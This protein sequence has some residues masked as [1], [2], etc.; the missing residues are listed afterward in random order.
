M[1]ALDHAIIL[2]RDLALAARAYQRLGFTLT[3][4]GGHPTLGTANHTIVFEHDY[5][6]LLTVLSRAPSNERWAA[7]IDRGD[8]PGAMV[9]NTPDA[10]RTHRGLESRGV[11]AERPIHFERPV[12]TDAGIEAARFSAV[13]LPDEATPAIPA[14]FCQHHTPT[15]VWR[16]P[17]QRHANTARSVAGLT[18]MVDRPEDHLTAYERLLGSARVHPRPGGITLSLGPTQVWLVERSYA[19]SRLGRHLGG[20]ERPLGVTIGVG[21]LD[22]TRRIL[23]ADAVPFAPF[24]RRSILVEPTFA[25]GAFLEFLAV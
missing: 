4:R 25:A 15:L 16:P 3:P 24:G 5:L 20:P 13:L 2:V 21:D 1:H 17:Y 8:G 9:I 11:P 14:F 18:V 22:T 19:E 6:E 7:G 23:A 12:A 10:D